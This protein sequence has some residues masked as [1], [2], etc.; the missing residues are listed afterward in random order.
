MCFEREVAISILN[1]CPL[2]LVDKFKYLG[3]SISSTENDVNVCLAKTWTAIDW[4]SIIWKSDLSDKI[5]LDS[6]QAAV[7]I[8]LYG[9][10]TWTQTKRI[11]KKPDANCTRSNT[12][13]NN[14]TNIYIV[15]N[16][17]DY[18][19]KNRKY[20]QRQ[21]KILKCHSKPHRPT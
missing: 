14:N 4:L 21:N 5:K 17:T 2:K 16:K 7:S 10:T 12:P 19:K 8:L 15:L 9:C 3:S 13:Q 18:N 20:P 11:E 6:F 1:G